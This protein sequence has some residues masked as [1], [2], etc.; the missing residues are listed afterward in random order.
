MF[1]RFSA[2]MVLGVVGY[3]LTSATAAAQPWSQQGTYDYY[4]PATPVFDPPLTVIY[5]PP[6]VEESRSY[7]RPGVVEEP[8]SISVVVPANAKV[9]FNGSTTRQTGSH[10][11]FVA[12]AI[13]A[14]GSYFYV[15]EATWTENGRQVT[16]SRRVT[17]HAGDVRTVVF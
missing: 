15:V 6:R 2:M 11:R 14:G 1:G 16:R 3:F 9:R 5:P 17:V 8:V 10:R 12:P 13:E 7:Y 4:R